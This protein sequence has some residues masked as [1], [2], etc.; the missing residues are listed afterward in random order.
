MK[1]CKRKSNKKSEINL[2]TSC[3][4]EV[5]NQS[6]KSFVFVSSYFIHHQSIKK[7]IRLRYNYFLEK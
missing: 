5:Q 6:S 7:I 2:K 3:K 1:E 4:I